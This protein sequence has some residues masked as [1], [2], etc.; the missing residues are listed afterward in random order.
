M[1]LC[2]E[3][4]QAKI[5]N[6]ENAVAADE[7]I[8]GFDVTVQDTA[9]VQVVQALKHLQAHVLLLCSIELECWVVEQAVEIVGEVF[10]HHVAVVLFD[11]DFKQV[12][13]VDMVKALQEL[14]L[15]NG[16]HRK[17]LALTIHTDLLESSELLRIDMYSL[18]NLAI[19]A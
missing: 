15:A 19:C 6:L 17:A 9:P 11:H 7:D 16:R 18:E 8:G 1:P 14:D 2:K 12:N 4:G 5:G 13:N 3:A 10:K